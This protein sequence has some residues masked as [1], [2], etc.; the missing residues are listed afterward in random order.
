MNIL[1]LG[2]GA[3]GSVFGGLLAQ[4]GHRVTLIG[5]PAH[6]SS[7]ADTGLFIDGI[8]GEHRVKNVAC[9]SSVADIPQQERDDC[10]LALVTVK[11]YDTD[12]IMRG[13]IGLLPD[14]LHF[15]SLQNGLGNIECI[16]AHAGW[17]RVIGGRVIFG[18]MFVD[19]GHVR[20][21]VE[22]DTTALGVPAAGTVE[23][24]L[25]EELAVMFTGAGI[26][27]TATHS[28]ERL[29]WGKMLYN[30]ALNAPA[31][32]LNTHY[33]ALLETGM[34]DVM[35]G[36]VQEIFEVAQCC[37]IMLP[38][39]DPGEYARVLFNELI[40]RT[41]DHRPSML[42]DIMRGKKTEIQALN[43]SIVTL[44]REHGVPTPCNSVV[45]AL[46]QSLEMK[47][48]ASAS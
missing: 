16:A 46:V 22:A 6:V 19:N 4:A 18:V 30:C 14:S 21:T 25:P 43:G 11:S 28:I 31:T 10:E 39:A 45:T 3:I 34:H 5:R 7:I 26:A 17:H 33:G 12:E 29:L 47:N 1:V 20:V 48:C 38:Y 40:P 8:W 42:Q 2:A 36:I 24:G 23:Q 15:V 13:C 32:I 44:G 9:Y 41:F 37:G 35:Q 27:T